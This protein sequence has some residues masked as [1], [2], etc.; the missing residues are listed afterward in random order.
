MIQQAVAGVGEQ[1]KPVDLR[2]GKG[3]DLA[4]SPAIEQGE[5]FKDATNDLPWLRGT[6]WLVSLQKA[7]IFAACRR[8][9]ETVDRPG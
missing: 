4:Q 9:I 8:V 6:N 3:F 7:W 2:T 5:T 1:V